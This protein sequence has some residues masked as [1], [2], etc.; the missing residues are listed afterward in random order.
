MASVAA[1]ARSEDTLIFY[2]AGHGHR[3]EPKAGQPAPVWLIPSNGITSGLP[4]DYLKAWSDKTAA[5]RQLFIL[6][7]SHSDA[8]IDR[9]LWLATAEPDDLSQLTGRSLVL[10]TA[11]EMAFETGAL[12][13]GVFTHALLEGLHGKADLDKN[14][15]ISAR[16]LEAFLY[17]ALL[18]SGKI[19]MSGWGFPR[20]Y[21][22]GR[23]FDLL[24]HLA[25][26]HDV[27]DAPPDLKILKPSLET[28]QSS[29]WETTESDLAIEGKA[30]DDRGLYEISVQ[31][32]A[33]R[34]EPEGR[35]TA[36][37]RLAYGENRITVVATDITGQK[38]QRE[39]V[40]VRR[41][42]PEARKLE[43]RGQDYALLIATNLYD[44]WKK[45]NNPQPDAEEI[46][47]ELR[48]RYGFEVEIVPNP[49]LDE[50]LRAL[51]RYAG[52]N[53]D[54]EDQLL[55][56]FAGHGE[57]DELFKEGYVVARD[58]LYKDDVK[59]SYL[60]HSNLRNI[61]D[62]IPSPH[63][64]LIL[65]ACFGGAFDQRIT[66][67]AERGGDAYTVPDWLFVE[68]KMQYR[69]RRYFTSGGKEYVSDGRQNQHSPFTRRF[70]EALRTPGSDG[71]LTLSE[72][73]KFLEKLDPEPRA[74]EF[75]SNEP[76]SDF[77]FIEK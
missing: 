75:G 8:A 53:Y 64:L 43:R 34:V 68:R 69:T 67:S 16:E 41:A 12:Q 52:Y 30:S 49:T 2:F 9:F 4:I 44:H 11:G 6:D 54:T 7:M 56:L 77:L 61:V 24:W 76:G 23:D 59:T 45:L 63:T 65:D 32:R 14:D 39:L 26:N 10:L 60:S 1:N 74:G 40:V 22:R 20:S 72:I 57:Y 55:I 48:K 71:I 38:T 19:H 35:F 62:K 46:A 31:G 21:S 51:R 47:K 28:S 29:P 73:E 27:I 50:I 33:A 15:L 3:G 5:Q 36:N 66:E 37:L 17:T 70:L 58:S 25:V 42:A 13:H 18:A